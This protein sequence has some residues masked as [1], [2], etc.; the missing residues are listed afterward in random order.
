MVC[1]ELAGGD[2]G[3]NAH[4]IWCLCIFVLLIGVYSIAASQEVGRNCTHNTVQALDYTGSM[5]VHDVIKVTVWHMFVVLLYS[6]RLLWCMRTLPFTMWALCVA[7][8]LSAQ[9]QLLVAAWLNW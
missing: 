8:L 9:R 1:A 6:T 2:E 7:G 3:G 4:A 5:Y